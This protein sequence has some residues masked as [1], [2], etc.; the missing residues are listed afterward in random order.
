MMQTLCW[1]SRG[2]GDPATV[3]KLRDLVEASAPLFLCIV[4]TQLAKDRVEGLA[5]TLGFSSRFAVASRGRS[6]GLGLFWKNDVNLE[7]KNFS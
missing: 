1:N 5:G 6:G 4:E 2:I 7:I 3:R